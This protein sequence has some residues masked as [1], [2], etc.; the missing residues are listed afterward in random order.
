MNNETNLT[1]TFRIYFYLF[2]SILYLI[3]E[4]IRAGCK[5]ITNMKE[6]TK[7]EVYFNLKNM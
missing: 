4:K 2:I 5:L 3:Y 6:A 7:K 1:F